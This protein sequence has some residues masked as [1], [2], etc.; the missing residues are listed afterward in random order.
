[1]AA[2]VAKTSEIPVGQVK[3]VY[4]MRLRSWSAALNCKSEVVWGAT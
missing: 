2:E 4:T 3:P 1:M